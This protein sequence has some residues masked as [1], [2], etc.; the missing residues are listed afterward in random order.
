MFY[1]F[2]SR[3]SMPKVKNRKEEELLRR[4][5]SGIPF[6]IFVNRPGTDLTPSSRAGR[7]VLGLWFVF[8]IVFLAT[9]TANMTAFLTIAIQAS[10]SI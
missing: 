4:G 8:T 6:K 7:L 5:H 1:R 3:S 2:L 10:A 9:Y